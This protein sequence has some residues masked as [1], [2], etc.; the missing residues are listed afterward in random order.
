M[1]LKRIIFRVSL[2]FAF[3]LYVYLLPSLIN[4]RSNTNL[5]ALKQGAIKDILIGK[6]W[7]YGFDSV[8]SQ[9]LN[10]ILIIVSICFLFVTAYKTEKW[11]VW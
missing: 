11:Q 4:E 10:E 3:F 7:R 2:T 6:I 5:S 1:N 8:F 9:V